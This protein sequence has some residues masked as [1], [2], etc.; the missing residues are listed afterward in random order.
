VP[1]ATGCGSAPVSTVSTGP[2]EQFPVP[3]GWGVPPRSSS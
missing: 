1:P 3:A 2:A